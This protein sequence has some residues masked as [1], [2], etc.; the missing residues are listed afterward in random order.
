MKTKS[1]LLLFL[2]A[3][4]LSVPLQ[5][6]AQMA[7]STFAGAAIGGTNVAFLGTGGVGICADVRRGAS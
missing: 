6:S 2:G 7:S 5:V 1:A 4:L 3:G